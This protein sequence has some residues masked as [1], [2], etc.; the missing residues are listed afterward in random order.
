[1]QKYVLSTLMGGGSYGT[2]RE[3]LH[4]QTLVFSSACIS[5]DISALS[6]LRRKG[7]SLQNPQ[8]DEHPGHTGCSEH[9]LPNCNG[10]VQLTQCL[11]RNTQQT[12]AAFIWDLCPA[13]TGSSVPMFQSVCMHFMEH[14]HAHTFQSE[15]SQ[16]T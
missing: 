1:M 16:Y 13:H 3:F 5:L 6:S 2:P 14:A 7:E 8:E 11:H 10:H 4:L 12:P 9:V 15:K